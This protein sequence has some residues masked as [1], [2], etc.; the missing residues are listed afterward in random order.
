MKNLS[1]LFIVILIISLS[2]CA[3]RNSAQKNPN[4][5]PGKVYSGKVLNITAPK[6]DGWKLLQAS[7]QGMAFGKQGDIPT[8]SLAARVLKFDPPQTDSPEEFES[9]IVEGAKSDA[10]TE[11]FSTKH[12][13]H[14]FSS[15]RG[16]PCVRIKNVSEDKQ[17]RNNL[18][19]VEV[20]VLRNEH[21]YCRHPMRKDVGFVITYSH[22]GKNEPNNFQ[23][24][25][26]SFIDGTQVPN[27]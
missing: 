7:P 11:R 23:K 15:S 27:N 16:Y 10:D 20:L 13:S 19:T 17:A 2:A 24:E 8:E 4:V 25:A 22:R 3:S 9:L 21:L 5:P 1:Y 12:F 26:Q 6:S 18:G 14:K